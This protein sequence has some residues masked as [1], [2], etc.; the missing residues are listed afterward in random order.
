MRRKINVTMLSNLVCVLALYNITV[1]SLIRKGGGVGGRV[2]VRERQKRGR[3][4]KRESKRRR[5]KV[6]VG[7]IV[8]GRE[9][10][11]NKKTGEMKRGGRKRGMG[12]ER[13]LTIDQV[14]S[15]TMYFYAFNLNLFF[16][17]NTD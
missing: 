15:H 9:C 16:L 12:G 14:G 6:K 3:V 17:T 1:Y 4:C 8:R 10:R 11:K 13:N 5:E 2:C 7:G